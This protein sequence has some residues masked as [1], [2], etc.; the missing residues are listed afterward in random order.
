MHCGTGGEAAPGAVESSAYRER[1]AAA[2]ASAPDPDAADEIDLGQVDTTQSF[3]GGNEVTFTLPSGIAGFQIVAR[4]TSSSYPMLVSLRDPSGATIVE[5]PSGARDRVFG[6]TMKKL[7]EKDSEEADVLSVP[8]H[9][10]PE[11]LS[12]AAGVWTARL[13]SYDPTT[14]V[15]VLLRR[16]SDGRP[17]PGHVDLAVYVPEGLQL[18]GEAITPAN[19]AGSG[20]LERRFAALDAKLRAYWGIRLGTMQFVAID[21]R[22]RKLETIAAAYDVGKETKV[23]GRVMHL[24]LSEESDM[25]WGMSAGL[26]AAVATPGTTMSQLILASSWRK[27]TPDQYA[28][29]AEKEGNVLAHE[30]GHYLGLFHTTERDGADFDPLDDTPRCDAAT[31]AAGTSGCPDFVNVMFGGGS[32][33]AT[34]TSPLQ[35]HIV[36]SSPLVRGTSLEP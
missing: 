29:N 35:R 28:A 23:P 27:K 16:T 21:S 12:P 4:G 2:E 22:F 19:A 10:M 7:N 26:P 18:D 33:T 15:R 34:M 24:I 3:P 20:P 17:A 6:G 5:I 36:Q 9:G 11:A 25:F 14:H 32:P 13:R 30:T 8:Q 1:D 31:I